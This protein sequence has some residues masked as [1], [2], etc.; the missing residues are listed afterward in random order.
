MASLPLLLYDLTYILIVAAIV[1]IVFKK[2]RQP[3]VLGYIVAGFIVGP[4]MHYTPTVI[5]QADI[6][7][8]AD[9]GVIFLLFSLGLEFSFKKI[10]KMGPAPVITVSIIIACMMAL[11]FLV[12]NAFGWNSMDCLFL[13][14]MLALCSSTTIIYKA[15][16]DLG[17][18]QQHFASLVMGVLILE[19]VLSVVMMVLLS[20][21]AR[22]NSPDGGVVIGSILRI[23]FFLILWFVVGM[24]FIPLFLRRIHNVI[25]GET[26]LIV[27]LGLCCLMV[28]LSTEA[29][30]SSALG[31]FVMGSILAETVE[32]EK[33]ARVVE[34]VKDLFGAIFF[35][36]VGMLVNPE[37]IV[38]YA[39]PIIVL[40]VTIIL[41]LCLF[42]SLAYLLS[43]ET[44]KTAVSCGFCMTQIG[45]FGFIL[46]SLGMSLGVTS[47]FLYPV[48]VA[49]SVITTFLTPYTIAAAAPCYR[50]LERH[51]PDNVITA[52][53]NITLSP[54]PAANTM[55]R[56]K[57][58]L[59]SIAGTAV[60]HLILTVAIL[61]LMFT[62]VVPALRDFLPATL[63]LTDL[64]CILLTIGVIAPFLGGMLMAGSRS[65]QFRT[66][67]TESRAN[68]LPLMLSIVVRLLLIFSIVFYVCFSLTRLLG[69]IFLAIIICAIFAAAF[70]RSI[71]RRLDEMESIFIENLHS[72]DAVGHAH[73]RRRLVYKGR[74]LDRNIHITDIDVP[75]NSLWAGKTLAQLSLRRKYGVDVCS[76]QRGGRLINIPNGA[77][78]L[79]PNDRL[80]VIGSDA[81][82]ASLAEALHSETVAADQDADTA[83]QHEIRLRRVVITDNSPLIGKRLS[84]SGIRDVYNCMVI[85][86][87]EGREDL[88]KI[89][90]DYIFA[91]GDIIWVAG[92]IHDLR[93]IAP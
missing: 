53:N 74:L 42:G 16:A 31:A 24:F 5:D 3:I 62:Y 72:R 78:M 33:I 81:E 71:K 47:P 12:G 20:T 7:T 29:G 82:L 22:G 91:N 73:P 9:I 44:L 25:T 70:S 39:V 92:E 51:L 1:T 15:L 67:W 36:S 10:I 45:E 28:V 50:F 37:I 40:S 19:D 21:I 34:P 55:S 76:I 27:A 14:G 89:A 4:N 68:H 75:D 54:P 83:A 6:Q 56:L 79:F 77:T 60:V 41:G 59:L 88:S 61:S 2:L 58:L 85:G 49:V 23:V 80:H 64:L 48:I 35:V 87:E 86:I 32:A 69:A 52:L 18:R 65:R 63:W 8:W 30:F 66:L 46:A 13:A 84:D 90:P 38:D 43:G 17:M 26:L 11:G 57:S 93:R